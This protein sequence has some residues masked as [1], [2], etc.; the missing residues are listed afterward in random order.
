ML[1]TGTAKTN[2]A[3][4]HTASGGR[5][6]DGLPTPKALI[7]LLRL[8][9]MNKQGQSARLTIWLGPDLA[10]DMLA[11]NHPKNRAVSQATLKKL[12]REHEAGRFFYTPAPII[13]G[14]DGVLGDGQH[15]CTMV[16]T[17]GTAIMVDISQMFNADDFER[18]RLVVDTGKTRTRGHVLEIAGLV[19]PGKGATANALLSRIGYFHAGIDTSRSNME[20]VATFRP[21]ANAINKAM[22]LRS[23]WTFAMRAAAAVC[24]RKNAGS[25]EEL[26]TQFESNVDLKPG[27]G[28]HAMIAMSP[29]F[30]RG[31]GRAHEEEVMLFVFKAAYSHMTGRM[32]RHTSKGHGYSTRPSANALDYFFG[33]D[34]RAE[35]AER[36]NRLRKGGPQE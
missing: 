36:C 16:A 19:P 14:P 2:H 31:R 22:A 8:L 34:M 18:A 10:R 29:M 12:V 27:M 20:Q 32:V 1:D 6:G 13:L 9:S 4:A 21:W 15:R 23:R 11:K 30:E 17:A 35:W 7:D 25:M 28:S 26:A 24:Y 3:G 33:D 5:R